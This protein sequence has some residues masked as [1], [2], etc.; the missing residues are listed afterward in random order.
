MHLRGAPPC[1]REQSEFV[2][3][4]SALSGG[5]PARLCL[6]PRGGVGRQLCIWR[7]GG[8]EHSRPSLPIPPKELNVKSNVDCIRMQPSICWNVKEDVDCS[9]EAEPE[10]VDRWN[11]SAALVGDRCVNFSAA[12]ASKI[13]N[14]YHPR[15]P[16]V[17][18]ATAVNGVGL[19][20]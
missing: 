9:R 12:S 14:I 15:D 18:R 17:L 20:C 10:G 8:G 1:L 3:R 13:W 16:C 6:G 2:S 7:G 11:G 4:E 5:L 19:S